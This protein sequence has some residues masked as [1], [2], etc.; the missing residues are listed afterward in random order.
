[1]NGSKFFLDT[2]IILYLLHGDETIAELLDGK[3][4]FVSFIS[5]LELLGYPGLHEDEKVKI[6]QFLDECTIIDINEGIKQQVMEIRSS[7]RI[8]LP[9]AIIAASAI[10]YDLPLISADKD[11]KKIKNLGL[12]IYYDI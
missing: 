1:M 6:K 7:L 4:F 2:N 3:Q 11:L 8:K 5:Q 10:F 9:D 12:V